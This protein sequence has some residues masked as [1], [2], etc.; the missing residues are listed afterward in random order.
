MINDALGNAWSTMGDAAY[1]VNLDGTSF[2]AVGG[3]LRAPASLHPWSSTDWREVPGPKLP[4][5]EAGFDGR[6]EAE[7]CL[8]QLAALDAK[9]CYVALAMETRT[10]RTYVAAFGAIMQHYGY[11]VLVTGSASSVFGNP[12]LNGYWVEDY[13]YKPFMYN[14]S[15]VR[16]TQ[17][18]DGEKYDQSTVKPWILKRFWV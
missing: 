3:Y 5:W 1:A 10:D 2:D 17:W 8:A 7:N 4:I 16:A 13:I 15:H 11:R 14:H 18:T 9:D 6:I 12:P